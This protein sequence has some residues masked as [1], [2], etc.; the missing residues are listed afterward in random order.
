MERLIGSL[1]C[2]RSVK[3]T[4]EVSACSS[5]VMISS[6]SRRPGILNLGRDCSDWGGCEWSCRPGGIENYQHYGDQ[7]HDR[8]ARQRHGDIANFNW[9]D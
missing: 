4:R 9:A 5:Q 8:C 6:L 1:V 7:N 3:F 2:D